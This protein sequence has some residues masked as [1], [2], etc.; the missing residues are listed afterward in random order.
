LRAFLSDPRSFPGPPSRVEVFQ[1]HASYL[2]LAGRHA[3]KVKKPVN[4]GFL[5]F[6]TLERRLHFCEREVML[7]RRLCPDIYLG[8]VPVSLRKGR[9]AFGSDGA[10]VEY[11]VKMRRL[12]EPYFMPRLIRDGKI[13]AADIDAIV[14]K[15]T[16]FYKAQKPSR[17][18]AQSGR[19]D[20]IRVS[21]DENFRQLRPFV[22][23]TMSPAALAAIQ[24]Y[25]NEFFKS[26]AKLFA[27]RV[28]ERRIRDCHGDLH[29]DH[30]HL[31]PS[32]LTIYDCIEFNDRFREI[33]VANDIAFLAMDL[34][35]HGRPDF[36]RRFATRIAATLDDP[37]LLR[38]L[39]FYKCYR[40]AV[41]GKVESLRSA[42]LTISASEQCEANVRA[43]SY[44]RLALQYAIRGSEPMILIVM[45]RVASGK[46]TL[47]ELFRRELGWDLFSSDRVRKELAGVPLRTRGTER[48]RSRLYSARMTRRT[49]AELRRRA[50]MHTHEGRSVILDATFGARRER[51][52]LRRQ[53]ERSNVNYCF[54]EAQAAT[55]LIRKRLAKRARSITE[56]SDARLEDFPALI[57]R[58]ERPVE[59]NR[60]DLVV[61]K[62]AGPTEGTVRAI[63]RALAQRA[64][65]RS[66]K[67]V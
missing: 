16:R 60:A 31:A 54:V 40:A 55:P 9:L 26:Q 2:V 30:I 24:T 17:A 12:A 56:I 34:D 28:R 45:G 33:D 20:K 36:S 32:R 22:K 67:G 42:A 18:L 50:L 46:S 14:R 19:A 29:L 48:E 52:T 57:G 63:L 6:S 53:L 5:N 41:R 37:A 10:I 27:A 7:N 4:F 61:V 23:K 66:E 62:V 3:Y 39:D 51:A 35:F 13:G 21:T 47:A 38:M 44:L 49:Y 1:T 64:S 15:L 11:A 58:Y 59:L 43:Q 8:V 25:T 65:R